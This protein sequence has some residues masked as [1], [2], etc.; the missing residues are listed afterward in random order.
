V[1]KFGIKF[2]GAAKYGGVDDRNPTVAIHF[3]GMEEVG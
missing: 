2:G 1:V 3:E